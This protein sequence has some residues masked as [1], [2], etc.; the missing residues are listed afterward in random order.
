MHCTEYMYLSPEEA[1]TWKNTAPAMEE[2]GYVDQAVPQAAAL[3][4]SQCGERILTEAISPVT[5]S[6]K[7][8]GNYLTKRRNAYADYAKGNITWDQVMRSSSQR[9]GDYFQ[10]S[11]DLGK[12]SYY[13]WSECRKVAIAN[14]LPKSYSTAPVLQQHFADVAAF[15]READKKNLPL[16]DFN[17]GLQQLWAEFSMREASALQQQHAQ[18]AAAWQQA[19]QNMSHNLQTQ[20]IHASPTQ[21]TTSCREVLPGQVNCTTW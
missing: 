18:N 15:A 21:T 19:V 11:Q 6:K 8:F 10:K 20:P 5:Y 2:C 14:N 13:V 12:H 3:E 9:V 4:Y 1:Q 16:L 17:V 7:E